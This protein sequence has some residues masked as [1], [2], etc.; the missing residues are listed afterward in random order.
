MRNKTILIT[1]GAK[2]I[3]AEISKYFAIKGYNI[4]INYLYSEEDAIK[5]SNFINNNGG[6][7]TPHK[8]DVTKCNEV[9]TMFE[10]ALKKFGKI[11][12]LINNAGLFPPKKSLEKLQY[13]EYIDTLNLNMNAAI[14]TT[15]EFI[16]SGPSD[17]RIINIASIG[18]ID[19]FKNHIDYNVSKA[20]LI[21]ITQVLAKELAPNISVNCICPGIVKIGDEIIN[22]S[23]EKIPM[24][25]FATTDD[26]ISAV[27]F[28]A[29]GSRY[30]TGQIVNVAGGMEL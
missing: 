21:R 29:I 3:G 24:K 22:F 25:R 28:F 14:I 7:A 9:K 23:L 27:D 11:D 10:F 12:I 15:K 1:G 8:A 18:G 26:I 5:L 2:R 6:N 17:G 19:I 16:K 20:G 13:Y 30:I 4:I